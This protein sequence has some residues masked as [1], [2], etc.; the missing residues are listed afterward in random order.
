[1]STGLSK[2]SHPPQR[3]H[4]LFPLRYHHQSDQSRFI[5]R[6][7]CHCLPHPL[8]PSSLLYPLHWLHPLQASTPRTATT[9]AL[10]LRSCRDGNQ[11]HRPDFP[12]GFLCLLL[13]PNGHAGAGGDHELEHCHVWR[14]LFVGYGVLCGEGE[15]DV[16]SAGEDCE[17]R[18]LDR[19][20]EGLP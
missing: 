18:P 15:E 9:S 12:V 19:G 2:L 7:Q 20:K 10:V 14:D 6:S 5:R 1:M 16:Y 17:A 8:G 3:S 4:S 13:L 11:Y